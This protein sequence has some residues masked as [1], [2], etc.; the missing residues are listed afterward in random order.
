MLRVVIQIGMDE[1][2][3]AHFQ[4]SVDSL[5]HRLTT[6]RDALGSLSANVEARNVQRLKCGQEIER[7]REVLDKVNQVGSSF[8]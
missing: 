3:Q 7:T 8:D 2:G 1:G 4:S 6:L 5:T